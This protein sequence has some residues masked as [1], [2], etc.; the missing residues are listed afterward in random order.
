M[1]V[2]GPGQGQAEE[3]FVLDAADIPLSGP[4]VCPWGKRGHEVD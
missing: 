3:G 1:L 4:A 2:E